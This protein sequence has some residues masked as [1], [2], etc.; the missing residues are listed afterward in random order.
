[1]VRVL[2]R[3]CGGR[4]VTPRSSA[5]AEA[6]SVSPVRRSF[7][8][9]PHISVRLVLT[10][11]TRAELDP[12]DDTDGYKDQHQRGKQDV[13][14]GADDNQSD[15]GGYDQGNNREHGDRS[16]SSRALLPLPQDCRP[17]PPRSIRITPDPTLT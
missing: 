2:P 10:A 3:Y 5:A 7:T 17:R 1:M 16:L 15:D 8:P 11:A 14:R 12:A 9:S 4:R 13:D 6:A